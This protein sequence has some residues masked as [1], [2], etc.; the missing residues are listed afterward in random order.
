M[1][2]MRPQA[3]HTNSCRDALSTA[4]NDNLPSP[5]FVFPSLSSS[6]LL[7]LL[8]LFSWLFHCPRL[9][10]VGQPDSASCRIIA[11]SPLAAA[12]AI[13]RCSRDATKLEG[14]TIDVA[15]AASLS[16]ATKS[17]PPL[18]LP[19]LAASVLRICPSHL[20][21]SFT[22]ARHV[23]TMMLWLCARMAAASS[24]DWRGASAFAGRG[25]AAASDALP[26]SPLPSLLLSSLFV[27]LAISLR[28][29]LSFTARGV[30]SSSLPLP[31]P[32]PMPAFVLVPRWRNRSR[33]GTTTSQS[34][35]WKR[36]A[37]ARLEVFFGH[38]RGR[39]GKRGEKEL[40]LTRRCDIMQ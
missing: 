19:S 30:W 25:A 10:H 31:P 39:C 18:I 9:S 26:P 8:L 24:G 3:P 7:V 13:S 14:T 11:A 40:S 12:A 22:A 34:A 37:W 5:P 32:Q 29:S 4:D 21:R 27:L 23:P 35:A 15:D 6:L 2:N 20:A 33:D 38:L 28:R 36:E 17:L 16:P 1:L